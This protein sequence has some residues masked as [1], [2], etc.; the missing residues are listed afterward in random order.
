MSRLIPRILALD[1]WNSPRTWVTPRLRFPSFEDEWT[2]MALRSFTEPTV[3]DRW[4][5]LEPFEQPSC[6]SN[7]K[8]TFEAS[9]ECKNF[10][11]QDIKV[12]IENDCLVVEGKLEKKSENGHWSQNFVQRFSIPENV[13][14]ES[15]TC[16][17]DKNGILKIRAKR[18]VEAIEQ[19]KSTEIPV[20]MDTKEA[21]QS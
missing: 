5:T 15:F 7:N 10:E 17:L 6:L 19:E 16:N 21:I 11:P 9:I 14:Q 20:Q 12:K 2:R 3:F 4:F 8:D 13:I 1:L 18:K